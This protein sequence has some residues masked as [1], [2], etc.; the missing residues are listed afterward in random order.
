MPFFALPPEYLEYLIERDK[1]RLENPDPCHGFGHH[2]P[3]FTD[4]DYKEAMENV[5]RMRHMTAW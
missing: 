1:E 5:E 3:P 4:Q 2:A